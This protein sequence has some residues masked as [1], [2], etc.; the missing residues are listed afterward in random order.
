MD[1][2]VFLQG[3]LVAG[4]PVSPAAGHELHGDA[5]FLNGEMIVHAERDAD[6][7]VYRDVNVVVLGPQDNFDPDVP[8]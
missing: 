2:R 6:L 7:S 4:V 3:A 1:R 5:G 8:R